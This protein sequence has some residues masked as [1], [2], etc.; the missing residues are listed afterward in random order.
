MCFLQSLPISTISPIFTGVYACFVAKMSKMAFTRFGGQFQFEKS[1]GGQVRQF[2]GRGW[3]AMTT[4]HTFQQGFPGKISQFAN[5]LVK[6]QHFP[7]WNLNMAS[8]MGT[9]F[10]QDNWWTPR[11][12]AILSSIADINGHNNGGISSVIG[13][14]CEE[15]LNS[16]LGNQDFQIL[17][18]TSQS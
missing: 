17:I 5:S 14:P 15:V 12:P 10:C 16:G 1:N 2:W 9:S 6:F 18:R 11:R 4:G 8:E 7:T 3:S 13:S